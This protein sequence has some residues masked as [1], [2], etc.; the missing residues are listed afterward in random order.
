MESPE[1]LILNVQH[2]VEAG[3]S[4]DDV[5]VLFVEM[6]KGR[7]I[8]ENVHTLPLIEDHPDR[9]VLEDQTRF[10]LCKNT[11]LLM[12][13]PLARIPDRLMYTM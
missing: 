3:Q 4:S 10:S 6:L 12:D 2:E 5:P 7:I 1:A 8:L 9:A 11:H 13:Q